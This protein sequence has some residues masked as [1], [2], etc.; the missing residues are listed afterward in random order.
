MGDNMK[1]IIGVPCMDQVAAPF[2]QSLACLRKPGDVAVAM[3]ISSLVY[4]ARDNLARLVISKDADAILFLDSDMIFPPD[5]LERMIAHVEAG[6]EIVSGLYF[7]RRAPFGPVLF[8][9]L[10]QDDGTGEITHHKLTTLPESREPFEV[11]GIGMGCAIITKG[12][13]LDVLLNQ[14]AWF[15]PYNGVGE[16]VAFCVRARACGHK[17]WCDPTL[18]LGHVGQLVVNEAIWRTMGPPEGD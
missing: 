5:T 9:Q 6:R 7:M 3:E 17:I 1:I 13:L 12:V 16:D 2:A 11:A 18:S 4:T 8:D 15:A 14:G 10:D